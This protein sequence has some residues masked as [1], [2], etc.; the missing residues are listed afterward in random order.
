MYVIIICGIMTAIKYY[1]PFNINYIHIFIV[2]ILFM[3]FE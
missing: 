1:V 3:N 2:N